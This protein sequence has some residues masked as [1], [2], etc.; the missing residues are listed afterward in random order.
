MFTLA[1]LSE[2]EA[3]VIGLLIVAAAVC[4]ILIVLIIMRQWRRVRVASYN[5][6]LK[7]LMIERGWSPDEIE[8]VLRAEGHLDGARFDAP[9]CG[10]RERP[11]VI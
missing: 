8:R 9:G 4:S 2:N 7:Q 6:R 11:R 5:A 10:D 3:A 1:Y